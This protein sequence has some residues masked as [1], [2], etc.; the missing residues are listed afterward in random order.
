MDVFRMI[1]RTACYLAVASAIL[2]S[3]YPNE[4]F[5]K[6]MKLLFSLVFMI[7]VATPFAKGQIEFDIALP[8]SSQAFETYSQSADDVEA[9][10]LKTAENNINEH[11]TE[12][13]NQNEIY[14]VKIQTSINISDN[15]SISINKVTLSFDEQP[16]PNLNKAE[17]IIKQELGEVLIVNS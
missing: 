17:A 12:L 13:L 10:I 8:S 11:L 5:G 6:Q 1:T 3:L 2:D 9:L 16:D 7:I 4:R 15:N 14:N